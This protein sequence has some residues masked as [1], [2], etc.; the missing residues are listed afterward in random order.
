ML[1]RV[2]GGGMR[3]W[4]DLHDVRP[5]WLTVY[6]NQYWSV[7]SL[8]S[9]W[10]YST[11]ASAIFIVTV[12]G[13]IPRPKPC[14]S[15]TASLTYSRSRLYLVPCYEID[16]LSAPR[17]YTAHEANNGSHT[18]HEYSNNQIMIWSYRTLG[19]ARDTTQ[20]TSKYS[21]YHDADYV[22]FHTHAH[23]FCFV[24]MIEVCL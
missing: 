13:H 15:T 18:L 19:K 1:S 8:V 6:W 2:V 22:V 12:G 21:E 16:N 7:C 11:T 14:H 5:Q 10:K 17:Q 3:S 20:N 24:I 23:W 4:W 9:P